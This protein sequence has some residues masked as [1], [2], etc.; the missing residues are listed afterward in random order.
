MLSVPVVLGSA[1]AVLAGCTIADQ[2]EGQSSRES[3]TALIK[4]AATLKGQGMSHPERRSASPCCELL[5]IPS[6]PLSIEF[7]LLASKV[8]ARFEGATMVEID[9]ASLPVDD[10]RRGYGSPTL[11]VGGVDVTGAGGPRPGG[12]LSCRLYPDGLPSADA[13]AAKLRDCLGAADPQ[14]ID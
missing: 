9:L 7:R 3:T 4:Q 8:C 2:P 14:K 5:T 10:P 6:C 11:L 1:L 12:D 13:I